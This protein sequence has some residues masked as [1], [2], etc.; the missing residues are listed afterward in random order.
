MSK[1]RAPSTSS[2]VERL[3]LSR[4]L[5]AVKTDIATTASDPAAARTRLKLAARANHLRYKIAACPSN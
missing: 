4:E 3:K 2:T 5:A 1:A